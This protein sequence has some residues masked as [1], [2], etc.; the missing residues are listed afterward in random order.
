MNTLALT[1]EVQTYKLLGERLLTSFPE[2]DDETIRDTLEGITNLHEMIAAVI[3][4][5]LV[6]EALCAG[7]RLRVDD[8]KQRLSRLEERTAKKRAMALDAMTEVGLGKLE[9][10]DFTASARAATPSLV[11]IAEETIPNI[12]WL[13]QPPKLDRQAILG[14]LKRGAVVPG[15]L[16]SNPKPVLTVRTK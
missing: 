15:A 2:A 16:L 7:L 12:Y 9:Q 13:P 5:A 10:P 11:V 6:D 8:M 4:S 1:G 3:R 14:E